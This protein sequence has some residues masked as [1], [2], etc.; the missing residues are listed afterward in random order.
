MNE[1]MMQKLQAMS[2]PQ[3]LELNEAVIETI[4]SKRLLAGRI[5]ALKL[6]AG[7][8]VRWQ[9]KRM[10]GT[11]VGVIKEIKR[12]RATVEVKVVDGAPVSA[13]TRLTVPLSMLE[14]ADK[15]QAVEGSN[16]PSF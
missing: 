13:G 8:S 7:M 6:S 15:P 4:K 3:L 11:S 14:Q 5:Q 10:G 16:I 12:T 1:A 2:E 9:S